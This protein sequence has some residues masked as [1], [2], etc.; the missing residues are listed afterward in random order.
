M[1]V[2]TQ[3]LVL[4]ASCE[5]GFRCRGGLRGAVRGGDQG[6]AAWQRAGKLER[7]RVW[8]G[9]AMGP[10]GIGAVVREA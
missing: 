1:N 9:E 4:R 7:L 2:R 5:R 6:G 3:A 10:W 8:G